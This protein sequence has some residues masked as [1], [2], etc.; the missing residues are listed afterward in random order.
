MRL[1][2]AA[3]LGWLVLFCSTPAE[4]QSTCRT[5]SDCS[6]C[7]GSGGGSWKPT[8]GGGGV[9]CSCLR[10][11]CSRCSEC[12]CV[13][14]G[15]S[16]NCNCARCLTWQTCSRCPGQFWSA[17]AAFAE[18]VERRR[19]SARAGPNLVT[20]DVAA[21]RDSLTVTRVTA[22]VF[23]DSGGEVRLGVRLRNDG[24]SP[25][26]AYAISWEL[27]VAGEAGP[28]L[29]STF[30]DSWRTGLPLAPGASATVSC[31][32]AGGRAARS[33]RGTVTFV[34]FADGVRVGPAA[35]TA[36]PVV[37]EQ[38]RA[39][40][41]ALQPVAE[42]FRETGLAGLRSHVRA[43]RAQL[44]DTEGSPGRRR[45]IGL[46]QAL[47]EQRLAEILDQF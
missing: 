22:D 30:S 16:V 33:L 3:T 40:A 39:L 1:L 21:P 25:I 4:A 10:G 31:I 2:L 38:R 17:S 37:D 19:L 35:E 42:A 7:G 8:C 27:S 20:A 34:E 12:C 23:P 24:P 47:P 28:V 29:T 15:G 14:P 44:F 36:G 5:S 11:N 32:G 13:T 18:P 43:A 45:A 41:D 26:V 9:S 6:A 46:L